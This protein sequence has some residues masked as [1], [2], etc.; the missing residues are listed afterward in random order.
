[1]PL[2][3]INGIELYY[4]THGEGPSIVFAHG[5]AGNHLSWW[6][7]V[8][9]L[10]AK[11][12][13]ITFD[14]RGFGVSHEAADGPGASAFVEDLRA[15]LDHLGIEKAALVGQSMGG[16]TVLGFAATYPRRTSALV[17]CDTTAGMDDAEVMAE[18]GRITKRAAGGLV[19]KAVA[20]DFPQRE[21]ALNFLYGQIAQLNNLPP[22]LLA[23]LF[24]L[25][26]SPDPLIEHRIPTLLV[27]GDQDALIPASTMELMR[28][29]VPHARTALIEAAGHS[30]YFEKGAQFNA[31]L[32]EFLQSNAV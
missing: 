2:A 20:A 23:G 12:R 29:R 15:L 21:P 22:K 10:S 27:W 19:Q 31:I 28:R 14:H 7:Q 13:C 9:A 30:V 32:S 16:W 4:E 26:H 24:N 18:Q 25:R 8:P 1:M 6:Q 5:G 3:K 17:L 11:Y